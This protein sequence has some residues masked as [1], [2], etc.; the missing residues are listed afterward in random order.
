MT[1]PRS[2]V[3]ILVTAVFTFLTL[4]LPVRPALAAE[5]TDLWVTPGEDAWGVNFVQWGS[6]IYATFY[7]YGPDKKPVWYSA[8]LSFDGVSKYS[9]TLFSTQGTYFPLPWNPADIV[10]GAPAVAGTAMFTPSTDNN[11]QGSLV[12][13]V[14]AVG[15]VTKAIQRLTVAA[16]PL[17][18]NYSGGEADAFTNCS[19]SVDNK[20]TYLDFYTLQ[21]TQSAGNNVSLDYIYPFYNPALTCTLSGTLAQ[22][23]LL[24]GITSATYLCSD[25][26]NT[27]ATVTDLKATAQGI[28]GH[29]SAVSVAGN[30]HEE[31]RFSAAR[32]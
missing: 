30:C 28:E 27:S 6:V 21:V 7:I 14:N 10:D 18:G 26:T 12:Y 3:H 29:F 17:A 15:T 32:Y 1:L 25:G 5:Y 2:F 11:Y 16:V 23:G 9:G 20:P 22:N 4:L 31:S 24:Y 13:T 8:V 19:N